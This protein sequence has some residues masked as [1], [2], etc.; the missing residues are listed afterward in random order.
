MNRAAFAPVHTSF[1]AGQACRQRQGSGT[2]LPG[3]VPVTL[4]LL[5]GTGGA[6]HA[7]C[8]DEVRSWPQQP[9]IEVA[10]AHPDIRDALSATWQD[11]PNFACSALLVTWGCG[12]GCV[13]GG[14]HDAHTGTWIHLPFAI[15]RDLDQAAPL[16]DYTRSSNVLTATGWLNEQE[17]GVFRYRWNGSELDRLEP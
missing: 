6:A 2:G 4:A 17:Q 16:L 8:P 7:A 13:T 14:I 3:L 9:E 1:V 5:I 12:S 11:G 10:Q 15:H